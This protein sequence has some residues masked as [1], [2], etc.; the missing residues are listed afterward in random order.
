[1]RVD[2]IRADRRRAVSE[3]RETTRIMWNHTYE[4][5]QCEKCR[6]FLHY[7]LGYVLCPFCGRVIVDDKK[8]KK[9]V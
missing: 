5:Y 7:R 3:D 9:G 8:R 1:M 2:G 4:A 6:C